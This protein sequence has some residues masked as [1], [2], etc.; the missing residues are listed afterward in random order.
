[1][2]FEE[3][4]KIHKITASERMIKDA[5]LKI[6]KDFGVK[7]TEEVRSKI[8]SCKTIESLD[9]TANKIIFNKLWG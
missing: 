6:L 8:Y 3:Y 4:I 5:K 2:S 1:M 7:I 9:I